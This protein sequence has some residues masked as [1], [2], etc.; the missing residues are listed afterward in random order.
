MG[1]A[2]KVIIFAGAPASYPVPSSARGKKLAGIEVLPMS[3]LHKC[4]PSLAA[5]TLVYLDLRGLSHKARVLAL[6][7]IPDNPALAFGVIDPTG[8]VVD[9]AALFRAGAVDYLGKRLSQTGL[10]QKRLDAVAEY[11]RSTVPEAAASA[12]AEQRQ[13][14][15][16]RDGWREIVPG[17]E[18]AFAFLYFEMDDGEELKKRY[19]RENLPGTL[20]GF[21]AFIEKVVSRHDGRMWIRSQFG[22]LALFP[23]SNG[24]CSAVRCALKIILSRVFYDVEESRLPGRLSLRMALSVG[25]T[26]YHE[27]N[28]GGIISDGIN[29]IF[30]LGQKFARPGQF[31][32]T[33]DAA[34]LVPQK[35]RGRLIPAGSFEG[36]RIFRMLQPVA[37]TAVR[38]P[39]LQ[40]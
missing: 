30:H 23:T 34:E 21:R 19:E 6:A 2:M 31:L 26:V 36:R 16:A 17:R 37:T 29:S 40:C 32:L 9:V 24:E 8:A 11:A 5:E 3:A 35:L 39:D 14:A 15:E 38:E 13:P 27:I 18:H 25:S 7:T 20:E 4:I 10:T 12:P 1:K 33:A 22:G 28:T